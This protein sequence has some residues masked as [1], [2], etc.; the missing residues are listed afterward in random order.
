[1]TDPESTYDLSEDRNNGVPQIMHGMTG[2]KGSAPV[3]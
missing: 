2:E 1:M 3:Q